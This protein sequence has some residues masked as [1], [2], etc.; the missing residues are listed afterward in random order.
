MP[1]ANNL[2]S[3]HSIRSMIN[4]NRSQELISDY[5]AEK[6]GGDSKRQDRNHL[7]NL[8]STTDQIKNTVSINTFK[9]NLHKLYPG[10][11]MHKVSS[12]HNYTQ[13]LEDISIVGSRRKGNKSKQPRQTQNYV[14]KSQDRYERIKHNASQMFKREQRLEIDDN[15]KSSGNLKHFKS[16]RENQVTDSMVN[17]N[18]EEFDN[19]AD[20]LK[21]DVHLITQNQRGEVVD[22]LYLNKKG[23]FYKNILWVEHFK[24][25]L[26]F[27]NLLFNYRNDSS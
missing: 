17:F 23:N 14:S 10:S 16:L 22:I 15:S 5:S 1:R 25:A 2:G 11:G 27:L 24:K 18:Y 3:S 19:H 12:S 9:K 26:Q 7:N 13:V 20:R 21:N 4:L 6:Y 8:S